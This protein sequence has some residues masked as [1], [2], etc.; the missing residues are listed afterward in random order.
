MSLLH[1][2]CISGSAL[3][4]AIELNNGL[5]NSNLNKGRSRLKY[6]EEY[7]PVVSR[8]RFLKKH[9]RKLLNS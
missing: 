1:L 3:L 2:L 6:A 7:A 4:E 5:S 8:S 9:I